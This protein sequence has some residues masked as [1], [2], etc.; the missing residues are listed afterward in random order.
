MAKVIWLEAWRL[1]RAEKL[2]QE[3]LFGFPWGKLSKM[4]D[5]ILEPAVEN[6]PSRQRLAVDEAVYRMAFEAYVSG[7]EVSRKGEMECPPGRPEQERRDWCQR[8]FGLDGSRLIG[9]IAEDLDLL[10][11]MDEWTIQSV[12]Y[13]FEEVTSQWFMKGV[14]YGI[15]LRKGRLL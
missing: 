8:V 6:L 7:M 3:A 5:T 14:D 9:R 15:R 4:I 2:R 11:S 13:F 10:R 12:M 1:N